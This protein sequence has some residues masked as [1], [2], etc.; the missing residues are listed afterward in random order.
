MSGRVWTRQLTTREAAAALG[1]TPRRV[2]QLIAEG[3][4][5][6]AERRGRDWLVPVDR[7]GLPR[8]LLPDRAPGGQRKRP[9][10]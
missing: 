3:R 9:R 6:G 1:V 8:V 2:V 10:G 5:R 7:G 4:I